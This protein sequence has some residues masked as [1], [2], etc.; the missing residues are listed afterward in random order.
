MLNQKK[1]PQN[2]IKRLLSYQNCLIQLKEL[3]FTK[4]FSHNLAHEAGVSPEQVR[5]DFS[6]FKIK[7]NKKAGY[8]IDYLIKRFNTIFTTDKTNYAILVGVGNIGKALIQYNTSFFNRGVQIIAGFDI[9]PS[10]QN[11]KLAVDIFPLKKMQEIILKNQVKIG[12]I[13]VPKQA[14]QQI[15]NLMVINGIN[16]ILNFSPTILKIPSGAQVVVNNICLTNELINVVY[17]SKQ[18]AKVPVKEWK[19][20]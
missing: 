14:S 6:Y 17:S 4:V 11:K 2:P 5:K 19:P 8:H 13:C 18:I 3:G 20:K 9:D 1:Y 7:G 10:K 16:G 12:I 15:C